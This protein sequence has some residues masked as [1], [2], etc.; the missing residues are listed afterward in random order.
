VMYRV[1]GRTGQAVAASRST[2]RCSCGGKRGCCPVRHPPD[3]THTVAPCL[4]AVRS[5]IARPRKS[6]PPPGRSRP[7]EPRRCLLSFERIAVGIHASFL[8]ALDTARPGR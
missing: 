8:S 3:I 2:D 4:S 5:R 1:P 7:S 6:H